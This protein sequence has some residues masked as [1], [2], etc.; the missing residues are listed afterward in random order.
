MESVLDELL[1]AGLITGLDGED[2][3]LVKIRDAVGS[4]VDKLGQNRPALMRAVLAA[5][6]PEAKEDDPAIVNAQAALLEK[7]PTMRSAHTSVPVTLLR[8]ML[9]DACNFLSQ[10]ARNAA[11]IWNTLIDQIPLARLGAEAPVI[12]RMLRGMGER[13]ESSAIQTGSTGSAKK[14]AAPQPPLVP[15]IEVELPEWALAGEIA[16]A[17]PLVNVH[18]IQAT[19]LDPNKL[20]AVLEDLAA[21]MSTSVGDALKRTL[22]TLTA[23]IKYVEDAAAHEQKMT[24][25]ATEQLERSR[26][27]DRTRLDALW[28]YEAMYSPTLQK[29]YREMSPHVAAVIMVMDLLDIVSLPSP[30]AAA[31]LLGEAVN[32]LESAGFDR[33][34]SLKEVLTTIQQEWPQA[35]L[36]LIARLSDV[37]PQG[38]LSI[39]DAFVAAVSG[40]VRDVD[41][42]LARA[43]LCAE[44]IGS[45]PAFARS[46]YRQE[47]AERLAR[48]T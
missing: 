2:T 24:R 34:Y 5:I 3:R 38:E 47:Q 8:M 21:K 7:W 37:P 42:I 17:A 22:A 20:S 45:L 9:L 23:T 33:R 35:S 1:A 32:R 10:D 14:S 13:V 25:A 39:R 46:L 43:G 44:W 40:S 15:S 12:E 31:Y 36:S 4:L 28:W 30:A 26:T 41:T 27:R 11:I 19:R 18:N 48:T 6:N 29:T 16:A